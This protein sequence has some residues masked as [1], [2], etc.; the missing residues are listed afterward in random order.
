MTALEKA[1][2][3]F[4]KNLPFGVTFNEEDFESGWEA[5]LEFVTKQ[6]IKPIEVDRVVEET[7]DERVLRYLKQQHKLYCDEYKSDYPFD[8]WVHEVVQF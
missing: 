6:K 4:V 5:A 7:V 8:D 3:E 1:T 2:K